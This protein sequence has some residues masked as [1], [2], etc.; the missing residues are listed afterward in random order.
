MRPTFPGIAVNQIA[1]S[2]P[3]QS[4]KADVLAGK[5]KSVITPAVVMR[6]ILKGAT[7][8]HSAPSG[9]T[10]IKVGPVSADGNL[11]SVMTPEVVIRPILLPTNSV[12][13]IAP[14]GPA[15]I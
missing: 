1:P 5:G 14:S 8:Y 4:P 12:N 10:V 15:V 7:A 2:G 9:P 3:A 11:N 13:H 6:P